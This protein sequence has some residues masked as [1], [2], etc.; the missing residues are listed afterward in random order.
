MKLH[1]KSK[2]LLL[3]LFLIISD[4]SY[5][6]GQALNHRKYWWYKTRLNND[7]VKVGTGDGESIPFMQRGEGSNSFNDFHSGK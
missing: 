3:L 5:S 2:L 4:V 7:F 6:Q 1:L